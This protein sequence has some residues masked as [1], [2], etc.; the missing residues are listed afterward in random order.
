MASALVMVHLRRG[1]WPIQNGGE[2]P[3]LYLL[4][5]VFLAANGAGPVSLDAL[6]DRR[7]GHARDTPPARK[8][9][10]RAA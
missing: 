6:L 3:L 2:L 4:V 9:R 5:F 1:G 10:A 8:S 7:L